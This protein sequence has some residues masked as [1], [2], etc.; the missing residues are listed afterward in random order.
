MY[1]WNAKNLFR[2]TVGQFQ[3]SGRYRKSAH[4]K[5]P[6]PHTHTLNIYLKAN[7]VIEGFNEDI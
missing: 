1:G 4:L 3:K 6:P 7:Q 5:T 2:Q